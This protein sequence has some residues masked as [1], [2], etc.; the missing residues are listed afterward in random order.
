MPKRNWSN[1]GELVANNTVT[2]AGGCWVWQRS[3]SHGMYGNLWVDG[4]VQAAHRYVYEQMVRP[5][6]EGKQLHHDCKNSRCVNPSHLMEV[7]PL[8]HVHEER[9]S[10]ANRTHCPKGH[11][12]T[13]ENTKR[14][15]LSGSNGQKYWKRMCRECHR[16]D[17]RR[18][19]AL[20][21]AA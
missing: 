15:F 18:R 16:I 9:G 7:T 6:P 17:G 20:R 13:P 3:L 14:Q 10:C 4:R 2:D 11:A 5:I 1:V 21:R 19:D 12:Y 8:E